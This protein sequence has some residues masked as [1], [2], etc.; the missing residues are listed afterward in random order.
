MVSALDTNITNALV[1]WTI[2]TLCPTIKMLLTTF[3]S[4]ILADRI[5]PFT[6]THLST[7]TLWII[8]GCGILFFTTL[9]NVQILRHVGENGKM[10]F[11]DR[12][13]CLFIE[14]FITLMID[15][16]YFIVMPC[17]AFMFYMFG[18]PLLVL[19]FILII[20]YIILNRIIR[21]KITQLEQQLIMI[22]I[23]FLPFVFWSTFISTVCTFV[24]CGIYC[25]TKVSTIIEND[26]YYEHSHEFYI[27][28]IKQPGNEIK[29]HICQH[30]MHIF[31][32]FDTIKFIFWVCIAAITT[33]NQIISFVADDGNN[34]TLMQYFIDS[35][36]YSFFTI[37]QVLSINRSLNLKVAFCCRKRCNRHN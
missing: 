4:A 3:T 30:I 2:A 35:I 19:Q 28:H 15:V 31:H 25:T 34:D 36:T 1:R 11:K 37:P 29:E 20:L 5:R 21:A 26:V 9:V 24:N 22:C 8:S 32:I 16:V 13:W 18:I 14:I 17:R 33:I 6:Y 27:T 7:T 10:T 12:L 23:M